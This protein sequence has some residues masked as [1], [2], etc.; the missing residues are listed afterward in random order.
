MRTM[1]YLESKKKQ[2]VK[3]EKTPTGF[4]YDNTIVKEN[5]LIWDTTIFEKLKNGSYKIDKDVYFEEVHDVNK[6]KKSLAKYFK[7]LKTI[8]FDN[9][10]KL[11]FICRKK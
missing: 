1:E 8:Y 2:I 11:I 10:Q 4:M 6:V 5:K 7:I 3:L 9:K